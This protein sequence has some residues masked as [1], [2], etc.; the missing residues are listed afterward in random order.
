MFS[1][2]ALVFLGY[3]KGKG[4][5]SFGDKSFLNYNLIIKEE[6]LMPNMLSFKYTILGYKVLWKTEEEVNQE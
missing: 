6:I 4:P 1:F 5:T 3:D 2:K